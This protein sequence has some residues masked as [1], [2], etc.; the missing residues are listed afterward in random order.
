VRLVSYT[1]NRGK[2]YA[3][4]KGML[5]ARGRY[6]LFMDADLAVP[7]R[8][9]SPCLEHLKNGAPV[10]VASR[11]LPDSS[12]KVRETPIRQLLGEAFRRMAILGLGLKVT[13]ITCGFKGFTRKAAHR[14]FSHSRIE[15]WGYDA[16]VIFLAQKYGYHIGEIPVEW[17]HS[18]DSKVRVGIDAVRT[19]IEMFKVRYNDLARRYGA[20]M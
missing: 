5:A 7:I 10:V 6:V 1:P 11:H 12:L 4:R 17:H 2:G 13:D 19:L 14:V 8:F 18:F 15:R 20:G 3:V 9:V 16:E